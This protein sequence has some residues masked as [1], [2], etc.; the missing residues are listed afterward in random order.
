MNPSRRRWAG[1]IAAALLPLALLTGCSSGDD[2]ASL[3]DDLPADIRDS[4]KLIV[5]TDSPYA[6]MVFPGDQ[7]TL[8]GFDVDVVNAIAE[9]L[10]LTVDYQQAPFPELIPGVVGTE[11]NTAARAIFDTVK[12]QQQVDM[13]SYFSGGTQ[14]AGRTGE[15]IDP[16][17]AC[18]LSVGAQTGTTQFDA[19]LPAK[20]IACTDAGQEP[21]AIVGFDSVVAATDALRRGELSAV[22]ADSPVILYL[23]DRS[24]GTL[25][26]ADSPFDTQPY[27]FAVAKDSA[28]G[29]VLQKTVQQLID[30]GELRTIADKWGLEAGLI[31]KSLINGATS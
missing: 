26:A 7:G 21:I 16:D 9:R 2:S 19:E 17:N 13:V 14:W 3:R 10:E 25:E 1:L 8:T 15:G 30:D 5:G 22:S 11:Y 18:G 27:A 6:P 12:R 24:D 29:P 23:I 4:G 31:Q 20:S 28:L